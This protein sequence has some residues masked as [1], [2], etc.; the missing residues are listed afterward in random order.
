MG[1]GIVQIYYG[2]GHGKSA[3]ALG[4]A[5]RM[6]G[7]GKSAVVIQFLK[8][9]MTAVQEILERLEPEIKFFRFSKSEE[10][11]EH[12][13]EEE[14]KDEKINLTNG[15]HYGKKVVSTGACD[16]L[17]MDELLGLV[18]QNLISME[19]VQKLVE[20]VPEGMT[21]VFTGRVLAE[22]MRALADEIYHIVQE[23]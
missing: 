3:A 2:E 7:A 23:K 10:A 4:S 15:F 19:E 11:F 9:K 1:K 5:I 16:I 6:T 18:D 13:T 22:G 8:G 14:K 12:L 17:I 20:A 21:L